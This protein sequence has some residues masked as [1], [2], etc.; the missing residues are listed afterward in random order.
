LGFTIFGGRLYFREGTFR[1][2]RG[3]ITPIGLFYLIHSPVDVGFDKIEIAIDKRQSRPIFWLIFLYVL[4]EILGP[5]TLQREK[6]NT[7]P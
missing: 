2:A 1:P 3:H 7:T 5:P 4:I 6:I